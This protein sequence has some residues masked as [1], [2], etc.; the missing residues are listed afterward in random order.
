MRQVIHTKSVLIHRK[1]RSVN[2]ILRKK[3]FFWK[4]FL[5]I[6]LIN[7]GVNPEKLQSHLG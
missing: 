6:L 7:K 1:R 4:V 2:T 5:L 3:T